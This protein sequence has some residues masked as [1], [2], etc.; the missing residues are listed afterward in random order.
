MEPSTEIIIN[1]GR[2]KTI[3]LNSDSYQ[4][5]VR[6]SDPNRPPVK[7][8]ISREHSQILIRKSETG[9]FTV[10][11][12]D[13]KNHD[14]R[15]TVLMSS[16]GERRVANHEHFQPLFHGDLIHLTPRAPPIEGGPRVLSD[17]QYF[18]L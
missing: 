16:N 13:S 9:E 8:I 6:I 3:D 1:L 7:Q 12:K 18:R 5:L 15:K 10:S 17:Y 11:F 2:L 4:Q 14:R